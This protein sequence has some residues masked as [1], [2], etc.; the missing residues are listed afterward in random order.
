MSLLNVTFLKKPVNIPRNYI[1]N[2]DFADRSHI[3]TSYLTSATINKDVMNT[4]KLKYLHCEYRR[5]TK[6]WHT[7]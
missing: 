6:C 5:L 1:I 4:N 3:K 7:Y 2:T